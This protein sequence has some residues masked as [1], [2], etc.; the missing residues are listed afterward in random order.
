[1]RPS[2]TAS[3]SKTFV[4]CGTQICEERDVTGATVTKRFF[5]EGEQRIGG[6][7]AGSYYYTR[8]H[9]GS[10]REVTD[11]NGRLKA[12]YD[13]DPYGNAVV[14]E[15]NM[16]VDFGYTGHY[17]HAPS[18]LNLS[19]H[20]AY[21]PAIGRWISRDPIGEAGGVNLYGY[22]SNDPGNGVDPFGLYVEPIPLAYKAIYRAAWQQLITV[23]GAHEVFT[24]VNRSDAKFDVKF[25]TYPAP[26]GFGPNLLSVGGTIYW[27]PFNASVFPGGIQTPA[28][29]LLHEFAH[30]ADMATQTG[31]Y[32][33]RCKAGGEEM[34]VINGVE[35]EAA[36]QLLGSMYRTDHKAAL[37]HH[38]VSWP[39]LTR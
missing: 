11:G 34:Y 20:R 29:A 39:T 12:R 24:S 23:P 9:L 21:N 18:G 1:V 37:G 6:S 5:A 16:T 38:R 33:Q 4:W 32:L 7:D 35:K 17:F 14:T 19:L 36:I 31:A 10:I 28:L 27:D 26:T 25:V 2:G 8:D 13:Y 22:V 3:E 15:G 30:A